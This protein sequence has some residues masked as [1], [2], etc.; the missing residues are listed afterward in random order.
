MSYA[1]ITNPIYQ[2]VKHES[3]TDKYHFVNTQCL[4]GLIERETGFNEVGCKVSR[5]RKYQG[6]QSHIHLLKQSFWADTGESDSVPAIFVKNSHRA[7]AVVIAL[8]FYRMV[9]ENQLP[10]TLPGFQ[11]VIRHSKSAWEKIHEAVAQI[12]AKLTELKAVRELLQSKKADFAMRVDIANAAMALRPA[13]IPAGYTELTEPI[14]IE[15]GEV[16]TLPTVWQVFNTVQE[17]MLRGIEMPNGTRNIRRINSGTRQ[18]DLSAQLF[19]K[20]MDIVKQAA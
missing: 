11:F 2:A 18:F 19:A 1:E 13:L 7:G 8:G 9:C 6:Y 15:D 12:Q 17:K 20:V 16:S 10:L 4:L 5:S 14:R 3:T